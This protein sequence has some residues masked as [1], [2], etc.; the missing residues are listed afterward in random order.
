VGLTALRLVSSACYPSIRLV[1]L[2]LRLQVGSLVG[3]L[4][5]GPRSNLQSGGLF[6]ILSSVF[7]AGCAVFCLDFSPCLAQPSVAGKDVFPRES[8]LCLGFPF[9]PTGGSPRRG[10]TSPW[11]LSPASGRVTMILSLFPVG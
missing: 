4:L 10:V 3:R 9:L 8:G 7:L 11:P 2:S 6:F 1:A 5:C